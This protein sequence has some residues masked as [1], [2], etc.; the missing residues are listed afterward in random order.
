MAMS[1]SGKIIGIVIAAV[2][3]LTVGVIASAEA[4]AATVANWGDAGVA[5]L[6]LVPL[7]LVAGFIFFLLKE[8]KIV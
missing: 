7:V 8:F 3:F 2:I 1:F 5:L 4:L 6:V